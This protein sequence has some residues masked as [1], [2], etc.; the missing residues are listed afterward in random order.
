LKTPAQPFKKKTIYSLSFLKGFFVFRWVI[1][2]YEIL[3]KS[4]KSGILLFSKDCFLQSNVWVNISNF[5]IKNIGTFLSK[6]PERLDKSLRL[7]GEPW[8]AP[9]Y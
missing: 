7:A 5:P 4:R 2:F 9:D 6:L 3:G 8:V 1:V